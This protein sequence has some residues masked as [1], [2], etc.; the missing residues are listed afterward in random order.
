MDFKTIAIYIADKIVEITSAEEC[1]YSE[2]AIIYTMKLPGDLTEPFPLMIE[3]ALETKGILSNWS[4]EN[5]R[6]KKTYDITTNTVT[7]S[8]IHSVKGFDYSYIFLLGLDFMKPMRWSEEQINNLIYVAITR[9][10]Y[11]LFI[12]F[13]HKN[14]LIQGLE[15]CI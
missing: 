11:Q 8:T 12:P 7:I 2:I 10:R 9:A 5:Y 6:A 3:K 13:I 4:S 15:A 14:V 1:P